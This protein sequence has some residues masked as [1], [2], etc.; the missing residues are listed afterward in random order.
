[1][2]NAISIVPRYMVTGQAGGL[3]EL[4]CKGQKMRRGGVKPPP[5]K[6]L[7]VLLV[8]LVQLEQ[9]LGHRLGIG[10]VVDMNERIPRNEL[11]IIVCR[12]PQIDWHS[13]RRQGSVQLLCHVVFVGRV[14]KSQVKLATLYCRVI[15]FRLP[16]TVLLRSGTGGSSPPTHV[17]FNP[18]GR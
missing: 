18:I 8:V 11:F 9:V 3:C 16:L 15:T 6:V 4:V 2:N 5:S 10:N 14:L 7:H 12:H 17:I 1:M 13:S